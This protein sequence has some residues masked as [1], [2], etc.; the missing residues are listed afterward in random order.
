MIIIKKKLS[1][2]NK[3]HE[4]HV[5]TF[6]HCVSTNPKLRIW[7]TN[8]TYRLWNSAPVQHAMREE[9]IKNKKITY[10]KK[11]HIYSQIIH[12][13]HCLARIGH[14]NT[15]LHSRKILRDTRNNTGSIDTSS[16][17]RRTAQTTCSP[18]SLN[19]HC[20]AI[21][22]GTRM[23]GRLVTAERGQFRLLFFFF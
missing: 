12:R 8:I 19:S 11:I 18:P 1:I 23:P 16:R 22:C 14:T 7:F 10:I 15:V 6:Y 9:K 17:E 20:G 2:W 5:S 3:L 4:M 13:S 21:L